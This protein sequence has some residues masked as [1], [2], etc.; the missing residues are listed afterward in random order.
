M[1]IGTGTRGLG[2]RNDRHTPTRSGWAG[3]L[4][5]TPGTALY[6]GPGGYAATH[7]HRAVQ[8]VWAADDPIALT[9]WKRGGESRTFRAQAALIPANVRHAV[10]AAGRAVVV[11]LGE[12]EGARGAALQQFALSRWGRDLDGEL[13]S[14]EFPNPDI[15]PRMLAELPERLMQALGLQSG[16]GQPLSIAILRAIGAIEQSLDSVPRLSAVAATAAL[17]SSR[18]S[19][20]FANEVGI[21]FRRFVLWARIRRAVDEIARGS[22]LTVAAMA[23]GFSDAAHL[24]RNFHDTFGLS[25]SML[26]SGMQITGSLWPRSAQ[27]GN[28]SKQRERSSPAIAGA[29]PCANDSIEDDHRDQVD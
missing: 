4:V 9:L 8:L 7:S 18:F 20:R 1:T 17:S 21:P 26:F 11:L 15:S 24:T 22:N 13:A 14:V 29:I 5:L 3:R 16:C 27:A 10:D 28:H 25:P 12:P 23:A 19:H 6:F 2:S